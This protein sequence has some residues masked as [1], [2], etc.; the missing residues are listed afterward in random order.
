MAL[1]C[2]SCL[3]LNPSYGCIW[4]NN[5]CMF[6]NQSVKCADNQKCLVPIIQMI[7]P[8]ILPTQGGTLMTIKENILIYLI[9][10]FL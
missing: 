1:N 2:T 3:Q 10:R 9:Y 5:M 4:C 8:V 6:K 7:E